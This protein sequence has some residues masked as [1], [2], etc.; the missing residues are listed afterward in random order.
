MFTYVNNQFV[1]DGQQA[2]EEVG[3]DKCSNP[4]RLTSGRRRVRSQEIRSVATA[5]VWSC[6]H[7][8]D[9]TWIN[10]HCETDGKV[11]VVKAALA[12]TL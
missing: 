2:T 1:D 10:I 5:A 4:K 3:S 8:Q 7:R 6:K 12:K 11:T 9:S